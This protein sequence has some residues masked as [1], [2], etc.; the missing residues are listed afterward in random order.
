[1]KKIIITLISIF[2]IIIAFIII[3]F[4]DYQNQERKIAKFNSEYEFYNKEDLSG[5]DITTVINKAINNN[6][7]YG[8]KKDEEGLYIDDEQ[9]S[10]KVYVTMII[11]GKTYP[12]ENIN[13]L[14]M[15]AFTNYFGAIN[16]KCTGITYHEKSSKIATITFEST[17]E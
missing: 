13:K 1:M 16:F 11:N 2:I 8:V 17:Q 4:K 14:G 3:N 7:K 5:I 12:M 10:I 9:N 6:E 15:D